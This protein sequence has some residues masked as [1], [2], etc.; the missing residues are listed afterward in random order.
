METS[1]CDA[2]L[3]IASP[4]EVT[5]DFIKWG[6]IDGGAERRHH[7]PVLPKKPVMSNDRRE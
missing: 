2:V 5:V 7:P 3:R 4:V 1:P 6:G